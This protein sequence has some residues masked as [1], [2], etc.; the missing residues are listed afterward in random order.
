M[1][2]CAVL[3]CAVLCCA[4]QLPPSRCGSLLSAG[5]RG[6]HHHAAGMSAGRACCRLGDGGYLLHVPAPACCGVGTGRPQACC[7]PGE[8]GQ[9]P[10]RSSQARADASRR[11][12]R[13]AAGR[14]AA[15]RPGFWRM[16]GRC[17]QHPPPLRTGP[18]AVA[19]SSGGGG[20]P[21]AGAGAVRAAQPHASGGATLPQH[22]GHAAA[23]DLPG[24]TEIT[25][26]FPSAFS[27]PT[28]KN[29]FGLCSA[30]YSAL[31]R[32]RGGGGGI[33]CLL[34]SRGARRLQRPLQPLCAW[35]ALV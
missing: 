13:A 24:N 32:Q 34:G 1:W 27:C 15:G 30:P 35:S 28:S 3:C 23:Q 26:F 2:C 22:T 9:G 21:P 8:A 7:R 18:P 19:A 31:Q 14:A 20:G 17:P 29:H 10:R 12:G 5:G 6:Q 4:G 16:E 11:A 33:A 25:L